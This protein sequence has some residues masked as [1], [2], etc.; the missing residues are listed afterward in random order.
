MASFKPTVTMIKARLLLLAAVSSSPASSFLAPSSCHQSIKTRNHAH[1]HHGTT[2]RNRATARMMARTDASNLLY[3]EQEKIIV[4]RGE[5]EESLVTNTKPLE[6]PVI[7]VR[8]TGKAG[9]FGK[10][11]G[12][13]AGKKKS[14]KAIGKAHAKILK[15][16]G[17]L[18]IDNVL[19]PETADAVREHMY[20][21]RYKSEQEVAQ[22]II[23]PLQRYADVLLKT[24]RCDLTIPMGS[25]DHPIITTALEESLCKSPVGATISSIFGEDAVLHE[26]SCLMSDPGSQRQ[27]LHPD[28]PYVDGRGPVLYT[29]FIA[30]QDVTLDMGPT[31]WLPRTHNLEA[32]EAFQDTIVRT[33]GGESP[34]DALIKKTP[35]VLGTLTKGS[36]AIFDSRLLHCGSANRSKDDVSRAL[37][38]FSFKNPAVGYPGNP[39]SIRRELGDANVPLGELMKDLESFGKGKGS[40]LIDQLGSRMR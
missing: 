23:H 31:V 14:S 19:T 21:L 38:Y 25:Q 8:G 18:R 39:A 37:F 30:L 5:L 33:E 28:T 13:G 36:C 3:E 22:G 26:F 32:H 17:V 12:G 24:N 11:A 29:C 15:K 6:A 2:G 27:V 10:S 4:K 16:E 34:K 1:H 20:Q 40:P 9:G 7:K 35:A